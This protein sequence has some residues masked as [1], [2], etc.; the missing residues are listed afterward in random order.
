M[1]PLYNPFLFQAANSIRYNADKQKYTRVVMRELRA[2][3]LNSIQMLGTIVTGDS[4]DKGGF[5][6]IEF[7]LF[8]VSRL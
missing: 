2:V 1:D 4:N 7:D 3:H 6:R 8:E 5:A